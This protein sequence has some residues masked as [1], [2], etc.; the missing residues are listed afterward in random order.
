[1]VCLEFLWCPTSP[2]Y[3]DNKSKVV[4]LWTAG[5][6]Y[7]SPLS[8]TSLFCSYYLSSLFPVPLSQSIIFQRSY[9]PV[10]SEAPWEVKPSAKEGKQMGSCPEIPWLWA[11]SHS[12]NTRKGSNKHK[13][14]QSCYGHKV[15]C[16]HTPSQ[17]QPRTN[18]NLMIST[19]TLFSNCRH[20]RHNPSLSVLHLNKSEKSKSNPFEVKIAICHVYQFHFINLSAVQAEKMC[21]SSFPF[22]VIMWNTCRVFRVRTKPQVTN[23]MVKGHSWIVQGRLSWLEL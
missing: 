9:L 2:T 22:S 3:P 13:S 6:L 15:C 4:S 12:E 20:E 7:I 10:L 1:M 18:R 11:D 19:I 21:M 14:C 16:N 23:N 5:R 17:G 8:F